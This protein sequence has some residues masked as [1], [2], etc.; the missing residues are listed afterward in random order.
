MFSSNLNV[1]LLAFPRE[2][3][4]EQRQT[5]GTK[6]IKGKRK[7][8]LKEPHHI[9]L[10]LTFMME[11]W[12]HDGKNVNNVFFVISQKQPPFLPKRKTSYVQNFLIDGFHFG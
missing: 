9:S 10:S 3:D 6:E 5:R 1:P 4:H 7:E 12:K 2:T 11:T 8:A